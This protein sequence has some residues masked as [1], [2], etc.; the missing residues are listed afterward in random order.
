MNVLL[1]LSHALH[2]RNWIASGAVDTILAHGHRVTVAVP[3]LQPV[4]LPA[5]PFW[6]RR[7]RA[8]LRLACLVSGA[9]WSTTYAH[10]LTIRRPPLERL[11]L[12]VWRALRHLCEPQA[13]AQG[14]ED[15]LPPTRAAER[16]LETVQPDVVLW[17]TLIHSDPADDL[18]KAARLEAK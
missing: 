11:E 6:R 18:I 1:P 15:A 17:P 8:S 12:A 4:V 3:L 5:V 10:K 14:V 9:K 16:L 13:V 2:I 7:L